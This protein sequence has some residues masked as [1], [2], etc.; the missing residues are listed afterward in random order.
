MIDEQSSASE[1]DYASDRSAIGAGYQDVG[2]EVVSHNSAEFKFIWNSENSNVF[3]DNLNMETV[4]D[5]DE[6]VNIMMNNVDTVGII[7]V[8]NIYDSICSLFTDAAKKSDMV[9]NLSKPNS[10]YVPKNV[11]R[12]W[13][14]GD[15]KVARKE[16]HKSKSTYRRSGQ[17]EDLRNLRRSSKSYK[18]AAKNAIHKYEHSL[19]K[20]L[21]SLRSNTPKEYRK[22]LCSGDKKESIEKIKLYALSDYFRTLNIDQNNYEERDFL[23]AKDTNLFP[24]SFLNEPFSEAEVKKIINK[25]KNNKATGPDLILNEFLKHTGDKLCTVFTK[26]FNI[27]L[28]TGIVPDAWTKGLIVPIYKKKGDLADPNNCRGI[29]LLSYVGKV[30]TS[31]IS[32]RMSEFLEYFE[33]IGAEQAGFRKGFSTT[34]HIFVFYSLIQLY[35]KFKKKTLYCCFV[36]YKKAFDTVPRVLLWQKLL[37]HNINGNLLTVIRNLYNSAKSAVRLGRHTGTFFDCGIGV[38]QGDNLSPLL[39]ALYLNDLQEFLSKAYNGLSMACN[40]VQDFVQDEDT[41]VYLKLFALLYA[42]DTIILAESKH[43]LQ[44]ALSGMYHYYNIWKLQLNAQKNKS[45]YFWQ[46]EVHS[47]YHLFIW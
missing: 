19:N 35:T 3:G 42:D 10:N 46:E 37:A 44:A 7:E 27:V 38:R 43:D 15:C 31:L 39:F 34:D 33:N 28:V 5:I 25:L 30:F 6:R 22:I 11:N 4:H 21:R 26:L 45:S 1:Q 24:N 9:K 13:F 18:K 16:Y 8:N 29:S 41:I 2:K 17:N 20:K 32:S 14:N 23:L 47:K 12:N 36:D 40:L